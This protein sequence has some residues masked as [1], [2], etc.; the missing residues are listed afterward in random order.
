MMA[1]VLLAVWVVVA[2]VGTF[3]LGRVIALRDEREE[4]P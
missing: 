1:I 2:V 3:G 4:R